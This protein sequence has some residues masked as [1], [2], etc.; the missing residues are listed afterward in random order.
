MIVI[1]MSICNHMSHILLPSGMFCWGHGL[2][3]GP[4]CL[5]IPTLSE[6][7]YRAALPSLICPTLIC[8]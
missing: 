2:A 1:I 5:S 3:G 6:V 4:L 8:L 7:C